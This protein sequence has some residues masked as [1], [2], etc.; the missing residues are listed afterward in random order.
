MELALKNADTVFSDNYFDIPTSEVKIV[1]VQKDDLS[2]S[3]TLEEFRKELTVR[4]M[5]D[6]YL[7]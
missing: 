1:K 4:S 2:K 5:Y 7:T 6:A 3:M